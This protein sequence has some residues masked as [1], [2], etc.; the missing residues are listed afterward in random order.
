MS[1]ADRPTEDTDRGR[2]A[3]LMKRR[4]LS[5]MPLFAGIAVYAAGGVLLSE[6]TV[7]TGPLSAV[8]LVTIAAYAL[9]GDYH[10]HP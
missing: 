6:W 10:P 8:I 2:E 7:K 5:F 9:Q 1:D 3:A 4:L